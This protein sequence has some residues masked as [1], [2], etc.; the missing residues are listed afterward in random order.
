MTKD[1]L[2]NNLGT[3]AKSGTSDFL[4]KFEVGLSD[5]CGLRLLIE[6]IYI[7]GQH[8]CLGL[9]ACLTVRLSVS[10]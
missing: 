9:P 3:I 5:D 1:D 7:F 2:V 8:A 10:L 4:S 6:E